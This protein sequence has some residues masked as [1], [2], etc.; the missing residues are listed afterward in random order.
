MSIV[1]A[2][3]TIA[4]H[5]WLV[6]VLWR[7][8]GLLVL[9]ETIYYCL[10]LYQS[11]ISRCHHTIREIIWLQRICY[12]HD[13]C[14]HHAPQIYNDNIGSMY[15]SYNPIFHA[16]TKKIETNFH[17]VYNR[18]LNKSLQVAFISSKDQLT[19][20]LTKPLAITKFALICPSLRLHHLPLRLKARC[21]W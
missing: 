2:V 9:K 1:E 3:W 5:H 17:F 21:Q 18:I 15:L 14:L 11:W 8:L 16:C 7:K 20:M 4:I 6:C 13:V 10:M 19:D 12:D